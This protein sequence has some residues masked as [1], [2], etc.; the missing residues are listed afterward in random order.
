MNLLSKS[1]QEIKTKI[2]SF[3]VFFTSYI[4]LP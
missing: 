4:I 1:I 2:N 3:K